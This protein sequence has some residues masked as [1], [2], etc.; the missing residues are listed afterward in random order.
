MFR[1]GS[2]TTRGR[3]QNST[4]SSN[5]ISSMYA[6]KLTSMT[7]IS[8]F[9]CIVPGSQMLVRPAA[10]MRP[11][12]TSCELSV[13][14]GAMKPTPSMTPCPPPGPRPGSRTGRRSFSSAICC[15]I[16]DGSACVTEARPSAAAP[17]CQCNVLG[18]VRR[19]LVRIVP[20]RLPCPVAISPSS[21]PPAGQRP[22]PAVS[23][24]R[25]LPVPPGLL[26]Q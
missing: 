10:P 8:L 4:W 9:A 20:C 26:C 23:P 22:R 3:W 1:A 21:L 14:H 19:A 16:K 15:C 17:Q 2:L 7:C 5:L 13:F 25:L 24:A 12:R 11:S 6:R 18:V